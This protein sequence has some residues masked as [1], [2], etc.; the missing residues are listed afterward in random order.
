M[1]DLQQARDDAASR[2]DS[3]PAQKALLREKVIEMVKHAREMTRKGIQKQMK[4][5][6]MESQMHYLLI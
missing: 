3:N 1:L 6:H 2:K 5:C 4:V